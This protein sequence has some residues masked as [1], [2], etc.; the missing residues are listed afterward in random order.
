MP[1]W[2]PPCHITTGCGWRRSRGIWILHEHLPDHAALAVPLD[3]AAADEKTALIGNTSEGRQRRDS[4][5]STRRRGAP[6]RLLGIPMAMLDY[7]RGDGHDATRVDERVRG[8]V[9][10]A[11]VHS[12]MV[13]QAD[14]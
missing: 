2:P 9:C 6:A 7:G 13:A 11:A 14:R 5:G 12:V 8:W 3:V 4:R 10:A 1:V